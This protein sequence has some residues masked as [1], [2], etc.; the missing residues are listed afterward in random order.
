[1]K[2]QTSRFLS[3]VFA[4]ALILSILAAGGEALAAD[5][6]YVNDG[7]NAISGDIGSAYAVGENGNIS[8]VGGSYAITGD[9]VQQ[10]GQAASV[11]IPDGGDDGTTVRVRLNTVK[12]GLY[13]Y[14]DGRN[15]ALSSASLENKVG[16]GY[17]FGYYDSSRVFHAVG[18][19][20]ETRLTMVPN[21]NTAVSGGTVGCY[22]IKLLNTYRDFNSAQSAASQYADGFPA[23]INGAYYVMVGN[24]QN[25]SA[26][27]SARVSL[28]ISGDVF[29]GSNRC[30]A[31]TRTGTT[32]V[33]FEFDMGD[34]A[35]LAIRPV[36]GNSKAVTWFKQKTYYGDF[37]Y[38]RYVSDKL[39]VTNV[40]ELEDYIKGVVPYEMSASWPIEALKAQAVSARSYF[41][42]NV[43]SSY[44][45]YGFDVTADTYSQVYS[46]TA[47]ANANSDAAV[48]ATRGEYVTYNGSIC[49]TFYYSSNGGGSEN[50]ENIFI[51]ALPYCRG[52]IDPFEE[53]VPKT[54]NSRKTW[55]YQYTGAFIASKLRSYGYN[56]GDV[57]SA[58]PTYSATNNVI[59]IVFSDAQGRSVTLTK[60]NCN[61]ALELPSVHYT[62]QQ[63]PNDP[64]LF[65]IEGGG[66]GHNVGM[67]QYGAY[68]MAKYHNLNYRQ[69]LRFYYTNVNISKGVMA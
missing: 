7:N 36:A 64:N 53:D 33:L 18:S 22:H 51:T 38:F 4:A 31:V 21:V 69:I 12:V 58:Q 62:I 28:G 48:D 29:T 39:T 65:I 47:G 8:V 30:V 37:E 15:T 27:N 57:V 16:S 14:I 43:G 25:Q 54:M 20:P 2:H 23:Y 17:Q 3:L 50:S 1:M 49:N 61:N 66:W 60:S 55:S 19:T 44:S 56:G 13:Y 41:M 5:T 34:S 6:V 40:V 35:N 42:A 32:K 63:S 45:K 52:V 24:Y 68:S 9:G 11:K 46:G 59:K 67:S 26:A 10:V